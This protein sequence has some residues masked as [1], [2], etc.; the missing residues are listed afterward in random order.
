MSRRA[1]FARAGQ[2]G[3]C[4]SETRNIKAYGQPRAQ[5]QKGVLEQSISYAGMETGPLAREKER[6]R[7]TER[8]GR[9]KRVPGKRSERDESSGET[10]EGATL[11]RYRTS[12]HGEEGG[13]EGQRE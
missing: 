9:E 11:E 12:R 6:R 10:S 13:I 3:A 2:C 4:K 8:R 7:N 5:K 1:R